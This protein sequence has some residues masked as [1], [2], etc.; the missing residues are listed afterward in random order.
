MPADVAAQIGQVAQQAVHSGFA[1]AVTQTMLLTVA[2]LVLGLV[3]SLAMKGGRPV[4]H[5]AAPERVAAEV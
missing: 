4:H 1:T 5:T 3:S 2:V